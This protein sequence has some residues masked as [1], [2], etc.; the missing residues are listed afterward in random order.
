MLA[1]GERDATIIRSQADT[2]AAQIIASGQMEAAAIE[3]ETERQVSE[4]YLTAYQEN[5][6]LFTM[7]RQLSALDGNV[8]DKTTLVLKSDESPFSV[9]LHQAEDNEQ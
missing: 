7:L 3:A 4:L 5:P 6:E 8:S 9:L 2:A 1:E